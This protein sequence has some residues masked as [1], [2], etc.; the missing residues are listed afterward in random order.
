MSGRLLG[1]SAIVT[2]GGGGIGKQI[3][4]LLAEEGANV[5]VNDPGVS[6][7]GVG[8]N[9]TPADKVVEEIRRQGGRA[10][11]NYD[12]VSDFDA[13][14]RIINT[15]IKEFGRLDILV[16]M[17]GI[18]RER[19]IFNMTEEEWDAVIA[20]HLKGTFNTCR[21]ACSV[22]RQQKSGRIINNTS[23]GR[24]GT[25]GHVNYS[26][27]K[28]GIVSLTLSIAREMGRYGVTCNAVSPAAATRMTVSPEAKAGLEVRYK[29]GQ[30]TKE[31]IDTY[32]NIPPPEYVAPLVAYLATDEAAG[33]NGQVFR[34]VGG[35]ISIYSESTETKFLFKKEEKWSVD[36]LAENVP[37]TLLIGY[38][39]PAPPQLEQPT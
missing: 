16:N 12:S 25:V 1:K 19:M 8:F 26:A 24:L 10:V 27:A 15:C 35:R 30:I 11:A 38:V 18:L 31:L 32:L 37:K 17:A 36:E 29:A 2:G 14:E 23:E 4:L 6:K 9:T 21:H 33:I 20:V 28:G 39:N 5:V 34:I 13:A 3:A 7:E 22:M